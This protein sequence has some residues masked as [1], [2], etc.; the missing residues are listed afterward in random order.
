MNGSTKNAE[1]KN[2][3]NGSIRMMDWKLVHDEGN[4]LK[5]MFWDIQTRI[6][7]KFS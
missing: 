6:F 1:K 3:L 7:I 5:I 4:D 2:E